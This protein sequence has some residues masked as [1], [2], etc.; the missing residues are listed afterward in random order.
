[1]YKELHVTM[2]D[3]EGLTD[4]ELLQNG[5]DSYSLKA[6]TETAEGIVESDVAVVSCKKPGVFEPVE[7][8]NGSRRNQDNLRP[9]VRMLMYGTIIVYLL[10]L[11]YG[12]L[13]KNQEICIMAGFISLSLV[14]L[15][16]PANIIPAGRDHTGVT[17][18]ITMVIGGGCGILYI[19]YMRSTDGLE[20]TGLFSFQE[21]GNTLNVLSLTLFYILEMVKTRKNDNQAKDL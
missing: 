21:I 19:I 2:K 4:L 9:P 17:F 20:N 14:F 13:Q 7:E 6:K 18:L 10:L 15:F 16:G 3:S 12:T 1:M 8:K 5:T 11:W